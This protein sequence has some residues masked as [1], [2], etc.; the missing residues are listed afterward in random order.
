VPSPAAP[1]VSVPHGVALL[2][3]LDSSSILTASSQWR[4]FDFFEATTVH[5]ARDF[6]ANPEVFRVTV[7]SFHGIEQPGSSSIPLLQSIPEISCLTTGQGSLL[8]ADLHGYV[9]VLSPEF[10]TVRSFV[11]HEEGRVT[12]MRY[13]GIKGIVVTLGVSTVPRV[14]SLTLRHNGIVRRKTRVFSQS[15]SSGTSA[16]RIN[17]LAGQRSSPRARLALETVRIQCVRGFGVS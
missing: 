6:S 17:G 16:T 7:A 8:V 10:E 4:Q 1:A 13:T 11:A 14:R 9:H 5:D 2:D 3:A 15:S 12:H